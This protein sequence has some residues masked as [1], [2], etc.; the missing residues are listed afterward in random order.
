MGGTM[1]HAVC[2][3]CSEER[4]LDSRPVAEQ[5]LADHTDQGHRADLASFKLS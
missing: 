5:F 1:Y 3:T 2:S 4:I